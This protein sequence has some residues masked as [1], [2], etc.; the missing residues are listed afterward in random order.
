MWSLPDIKQMNARKA[1][2]QKQLKREANLGKS[3]K[4]ACENCGKPSTVHLPYYDIFSD[5]ISGVSHLCDECNDRC[6]D[7]DMFTCEVCERRM[8]DHITWERYQVNIG[9]VC[10]C[11]SCAAKAYFG[12]KENE[13]DL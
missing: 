1:A 2:S 8:L 5:D 11:L 7:E 10:M 12:A 4:H 13:I 6:G 9:G 3:K